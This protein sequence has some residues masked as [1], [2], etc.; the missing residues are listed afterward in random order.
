MTL[1]KDWKLDNLLTIC[2]NKVER[3]KDLV[4]THHSGAGI[5]KDKWD[6]GLSLQRLG[7]LVQDD[8]GECARPQQRGHTPRAREGRHDD[9]SVDK[10]LECDEEKESFYEFRV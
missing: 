6:D 4:C 5:S 2:L 9:I 7:G 8:V 3:E 10:I 1:Y